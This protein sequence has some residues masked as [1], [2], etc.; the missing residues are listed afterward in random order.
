[1][2]VAASATRDAAATARERRKRL[3]RRRAFASVQTRVADVLRAV[4]ARD[5]ARATR[6]VRDADDALDEMEDAEEGDD[7]RLMAAAHG[8]V[9]A[10]FDAAVSAALAAL[11]AAT[12]TSTPEGEDRAVAAFD[13]DAATAAWAGVDGFLARS[14][15]SCC[16][17]S[18]EARRRDG[19]EAVASALERDVVAP[20][21]AFLAFGC[22]ASTREDDPRSVSLHISEDSMT[23]K[24]DVAEPSASSRAIALAA[25]M[26]TAASFLG[27]SVA[28]ARARGKICA[29]AWGAVS[30]AVIAAWFVGDDAQLSEDAVDALC[31]AEATFLAVAGPGGGGGVGGD[32]DDDDDDE[33]ENENENEKG[34]PGT[35]SSSLACAN[36]TDDGIAF[37][38]IEQA[39]LEREGADAGSARTRALARARELLLE[40]EKTRATTT[41]TTPTDEASSRL[42]ALSPPSCVVSATAV[43]LASHVA[44]LVDESGREYAANTGESGAATSSS[45]RRCA[46]ELA[47]AAADA[48]D[49]YRALVPALRGG[50]LGGEEDE[51][52]DAEEIGD[53][54]GVAGIVRGGPEATVVFR[55]DAHYLA[56]AW[57]AAAFAR[58]DADADAGT[59]TDRTRPTP[60]PLPVGVVPPLLAA[61]DAALAMLATRC[62]REIDRILDD[63]RGFNRVK[64]DGA[65]RATRALR[66]ARHFLARVV[67]PLVRALPS[68]LGENV[69]RGLLEGYAR[70]VVDDVFA[71]KD[72]SAEDSSALRDALAEVAFQPRGLV[73]PAD[74]S[75]DGDGDG[76]GDGGKTKESRVADADAVAIALVESLPLRSRWGKGLAL[77]KMLDAKMVKIASQARPIHT[78][79]HTTALAW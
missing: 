18:K 21:A 42:G 33:N 77:V 39:A 32:D 45:S 66:R 48:L 28:S 51:E 60:P 63:A 68:P 49:L 47:T 3:E 78:G 72:I 26:E 4:D 17:N 22:A 30:S 35:P 70:R 36:A 13:V 12:A 64:D 52:D 55:N 44:D 6:G 25:A 10:A 61:G 69:A 43:A 14:A 59:S 54:H 62:G 31:A 65:A 27:R 1:M 23:W 67:T 46:N 58:G 75:G 38:P 50:A 74:A 37:G 15:G 73:L 5:F 29:R 57:L 79:P 19:R 16:S 8:D 34:K 71:L 24:S 56:A 9:A 76:D 2:A 20:L 41:T 53:E 7:A 40:G 11:A